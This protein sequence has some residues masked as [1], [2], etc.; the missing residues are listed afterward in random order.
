MEVARQTSS[1]W[2]P[3]VMERPIIDPNWKSQPTYSRKEFMDELAHRVG[4][5]YG[6]ADIRDAQ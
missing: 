3:N 4:S 1:D 5:H 2:S 6:L